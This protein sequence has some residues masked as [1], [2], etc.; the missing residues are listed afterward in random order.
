MAGPRGV[1]AGSRPWGRSSVAVFGGARE[2]S[3]STVRRSSVVRAGLVWEDVGSPMLQALVR[4]LPLSL[5]LAS[6]C[7]EPRAR[8]DL[9]VL[10]A[11]SMAPAVEA[12]A[13][14]AGGA[15]PVRVSSAGSNTLAHQLRHGVDAALFVSA[16]R[17]WADAV[18]ETG[19]G[20]ERCVLASNELALI[21]PAGNP[22]GVASVRDLAE[23][24]VRRIALAGENVPAGSYADAALRASGLAEAVASKVVRGSS[25]RVALGYV[26]RGEVDAG[27]VYASDVRLSDGVELVER[28]DPETHPRIE[29]HLL[30]LSPEPAARALY[31][32]L[33]GPEGRARLAEH[34]FVVAAR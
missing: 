16:H 11:A 21:V 12:I 2:T 9:L 14:D 22:A 15:R 3:R 23:D 33:S 20:T 34:G 6:A 7:G 4:R 13:K 31:D 8:E 19:A 25:V 26:A 32:A 28:L 18:W 1:A 17:A 10:C 5:V 29:Y 27:I 30:L 24:A